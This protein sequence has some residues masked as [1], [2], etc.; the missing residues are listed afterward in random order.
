MDD[1]PWKFEPLVDITFEEVQELNAT[2]QGIQANHT[3]SLSPDL[4]RH[5]VHDDTGKR[6]V[7][8]ATSIDPDEAYK[9]AMKGL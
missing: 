4:A 3:D 8:T 2:M 9:R 6:G 5:F 7:G 1:H